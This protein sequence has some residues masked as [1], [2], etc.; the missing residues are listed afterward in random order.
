MMTPGAVRAVTSWACD[1]LWWLLCHFCFLS[2]PEKLTGA[3]QVSGPV[4]LGSNVTRDELFLPEVPLFLTA[5]LPQVAKGQWDF[6]P[7]SAHYNV[8]R[9]FPAWALTYQGCS[10][11]ILQFKM[12]CI[13]TRDISFYTFSD[14]TRCKWIERRWICSI[15]NEVTFNMKASEKQHTTCNQPFNLEGSTH[16]MGCY[17]HQGDQHV[18]RKAKFWDV[19]YLFS[20][21]L[22]FVSN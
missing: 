5:H 4:L 20:I 6:L 16:R 22:Q 10:L 3:N 12:K 11:L 2:E 21:M 15:G 14:Y 18:F 19:S 17:V 8:I 7:A 13:I 1:A 9:Q